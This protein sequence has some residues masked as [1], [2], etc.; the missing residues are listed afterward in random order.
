MANIGLAK[1]AVETSP[2]YINIWRIMQRRWSQALFSG[3]Q[4]Q[5]KRQWA[6]TET[7]QVPSEHQETLLL[8]QWSNIGT[9]CPRRLWNLSSWRYSKTTWTQ[10]WATSSKWQSL[11]MEAG[12]DDLQRY[13]PTPTILWFCDSVILWFCDSVILWKEKVK[14]F[15]YVE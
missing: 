2:M 4:W 12:P 15:T 10:S 14:S 11:R 6:H 5:D 3:A 7:Q 1:T 8:W 13:F 9:D